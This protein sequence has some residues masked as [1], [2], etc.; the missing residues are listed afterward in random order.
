LD[1]DD[2]KILI[3]CGSPEDFCFPPS[4]GDIISEEKVEDG[5]EEEK[6]QQQA[7]RKAERPLDEILEE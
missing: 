6:E 3:D 7:L 4:S 1:I 2:V 5:D